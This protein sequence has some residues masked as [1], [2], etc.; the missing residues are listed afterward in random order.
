MKRLF[1]D[2]FPLRDEHPLR[3]EHLKIDDY[4][5]EAR[6]RFGSRLFSFTWES[7]PELLHAFQAFKIGAAAPRARIICAS[8]ERLEHGYPK[9]LENGLAEVAPALTDLYSRL[10][11]R[12]TAWKPEDLQPILISFQKIQPSKSLPSAPLPV[13]VLFESLERSLELY[14]PPS[15]FLEALQTLKDSFLIR[16]FTCAREPKPGSVI[17]EEEV[18]R[19]SRLRSIGEQALALRVDLQEHWAKVAMWD[20]RQVRETDPDSAQ[21]WFELFRLGAYLKNNN[22]AE[23]LTDQISTCLMRIGLPAFMSYCERWLSWVGREPADRSQARS[24]GSEYGLANTDPSAASKRKSKEP[25]SELNVRAWQ[26]LIAGIAAMQP[27]WAA[28]VLGDLGEVAL[29]RVQSKSRSLKLGKR[30]LQ[31]LSEIPWIEAEQRLFTLR[32]STRLPSIKKWI[33]ERLLERHKLGA[34]DL[35]KLDR[36]EELALTHSETLSADFTITFS[37]NSESHK[38]TEAFPIDRRLSHPLARITYLKNPTHPQLDAKIDPTLQDALSRLRSTLK[39]HSTRLETTLRWGRVWSLQEWQSI[40]WD[41]P[42]F[43]LLASRLIWQLNDPFEERLESALIQPDQIEIE[44]GFTSPATS[45]DSQLK[46]INSNGRRLK[47][48]GFKTQVRLWNPLQ[49]SIEDVISW[50]RYMEEFEIR[51]PFKQAHREIYILTDAERET[52]VFSN[53]FAAHFLKQSKLATI[54]REIGWKYQPVGYWNMDQGSQACAERCVEELGI[55]ARYRMKPAAGV[56]LNEGITT[57]RRSKSGPMPVVTS[58]RAE[59]YKN[60]KPMRLTEVP[61]GLFSECMRDIDL[62]VGLCSI[63][64]DPEWGRTDNHPGMQ[65]YWRSFAFGE[66]TETAKSRKEILKRLTPRLHIAKQLELTERYLIVRG[67]I[68]SYKIHLGSGNILMEPNDEYLC[69]VP[70]PTA[71]KGEAGADI[72]GLP[73]EG[74][75]VLSIILSK[76]FL[77]ANDHRIQDPV[78]LNQIHP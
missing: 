40:Y 25:M 58:D 3:E 37:S 66:L 33:T 65:R 12:L 16:P 63:G 36:L 75:R 27:N 42:Q 28:K 41:L 53:R 32:R 55:V 78:I 38:K 67:Q 51:Q 1:P 68:R 21:G 71:N 77:L 70:K 60:G 31:A 64:A 76:A 7:Q 24:K 57:N 26:L 46:W 47:D 10:L 56:E 45:N 5:R 49:S 62:M 50:R 9:A 4:L 29:E 22:S 39:D 8:L 54:C 18:R 59:F 69:I 19:I 23:G 30:A 20:W 61:G 17:P 35:S 6:D 72:Q 15:E 48:F 52:G 13:D 14:H 34:N 44:D 73:F 43:R 11:Q 74:D 2:R